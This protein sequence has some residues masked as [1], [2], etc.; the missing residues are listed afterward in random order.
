VFWSV[1]RALNTPHIPGIALPTSMHH[2]S[3]C[4]AQQQQ[5]HDWPRPAVSPCA[6]LA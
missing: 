6:G 3:A 2:A 4:L 1:S 5:H